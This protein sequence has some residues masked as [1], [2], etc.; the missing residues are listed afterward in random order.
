MIAKK[1]PGADWVYMVYDVRDRVVMTQDGEQRKANKWAYTLYDALN[2]PVVTGI[3]SPGVSLDQ[4]AMAW[5]ISKVPTLY[6]TFTGTG[7]GAIHGYSNTVFTAPNFLPVG[8]EPM[9]VTYYDTYDFRAGWG[10]EY[11]YDSAQVTPVTT[12]GYISRQPVRSL[13]T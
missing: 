3:Y 2:R 4:A 12:N 7:I 1:L 8:F 13:T 11:V 5:R 10:N 6:E 9:V